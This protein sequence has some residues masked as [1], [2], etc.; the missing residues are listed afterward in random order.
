MGND[1]KDA[2]DV[3]CVRD[4]NIA[5]LAMR[6]INNIM[7]DYLGPVN[8]V[9]T[10]DATAQVIEETLEERKQLRQEFEGQMKELLDAQQAADSITWRMELGTP[11]DGPSGIIAETGGTIIL[12]GHAYGGSGYWV[13]DREGH[14]RFIEDAWVVRAGD[15]SP[16]GI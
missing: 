6:K 15:T 12:D 13:R 16:M 2:I 14:R 7:D 10:L 11:K 4:R 1:T 8:A 9:D 3:F 5:A